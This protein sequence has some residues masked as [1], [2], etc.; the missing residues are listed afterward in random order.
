[1]GIDAVARET[2][3]NNRK[4]IEEVLNDHNPLSSS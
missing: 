3:K 4:K 1:M 2:L